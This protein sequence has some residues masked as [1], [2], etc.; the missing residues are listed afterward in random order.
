MPKRKS[1]RMRLPNGFGQISEIRNRRLRKP[2]RA[3]ITVGKTDTGKPICKPLKPVTY[4]ATYNEAY[5]AL[6]KYH[7]KPC[8]YSADMTLN[9]LYEK[10]FEY[11]MSTGITESTIRS[12]K[13][14]WRYCE[15]VYDVLLSDVRP[16]HIRYCIDHG[17]R[18]INGVER[19]PTISM[20]RRIKANFNKMFDFAIEYGY[21]DQNYSRMLKEVTPETKYAKKAEDPHISFTDE[22]MTTLWKYLEDIPLAKVVLIQCY[23]GWRPNELGKIKINDVDLNNWTFTGGMKTRAGID[24]IVPIHKK[25]RP[26]VLDKYNEAKKIRS[27]YLMNV[28]LDL[29]S[30]DDLSS[31]NRYYHQF[32]RLVKKLDL[33]PKHRPHDPRKHFVTMAKSS[34]VD[35]YAIKYLIGHTIEDLTERVYTDRDIEWLREEIEKIK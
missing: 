24:R 15:S 4:F 31:Y 5:E 12:V 6:V 34:G 9:D 11:H 13:A 26:L 18:V 7:Q 27:E 33:N 25:I 20:K 30:Y 22:E 10:W 28:K 16:R 14:A 23:S 2:F 32:K 21:A 29:G 8:D 35:E 1:K 3:M 19:V 17:S